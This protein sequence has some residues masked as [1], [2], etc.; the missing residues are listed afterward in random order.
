VVKAIEARR[1]NSHLELVNEAI[2]VASLQQLPLAVLAAPILD[3]PIARL[4]PDEIR[5]LITMFLE[6]TVDP[7]AEPTFDL[8][9]HVNSHLFYSYA[10]LEDYR[11]LERPARTTLSGCDAVTYRAAYTM[12]HADTV[13]RCPVR[14]RS[15][16]VRRGPDVYSIRMADYPDRDPRLAFDFTGV[17][18]SICLS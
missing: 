5:P 10:L 3:D 15:Y 16:F 9:E 4:G 8:L 7:A 13:D 18:E 14:H 1:I 6:D 11:L 12:L 2:R 17:V